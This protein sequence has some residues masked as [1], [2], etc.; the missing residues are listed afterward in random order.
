MHG[1]CA[2]D[3]DGSPAFER[4]QWRPERVPLADLPQLLQQRQRLGF[5]LGHDD[6]HLSLPD[7]TEIKFCREGDLH[8][9]SGH[10]PFARNLA[11]ALLNRNILLARRPA[12]LAP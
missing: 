7:G 9:R 2:S 11:Q 1:W 4:L 5:R 12:T 8:V 3:F 10:E 6:L